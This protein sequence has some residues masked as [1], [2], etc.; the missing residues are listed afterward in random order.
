[1]KKVYDFLEEG[2]KFKGEFNG[3]FSDVYPL[4]QCRTDKGYYKVDIVKHKV[5]RKCFFS[6][7]TVDFE[8]G[9]AVL[10]LKNVG[11]VVGVGLVG[12]CGV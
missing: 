11:E 7:R 10:E 9:V 2:M 4:F 3:T 1:M 12:G 6:Y 8:Q 5:T